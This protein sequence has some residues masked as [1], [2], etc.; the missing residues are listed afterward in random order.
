MRL[1]PC[2]FKHKKPGSFVGLWGDSPSFYVG[3]FGDNGCGLTGPR[4]ADA[5][6]AMRKWNRREKSAPRGDA[7]GGRA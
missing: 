4:D 2:P 6:K 3:C 7:G 1:K 5:D